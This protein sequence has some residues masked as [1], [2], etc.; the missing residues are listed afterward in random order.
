MHQARL[1]IGD[2]LP[3][4]RFFALANL[5]GSLRRVATRWVSGTHLSRFGVLCARDA[6]RVSGTKQTARLQLSRSTAWFVCTK[7]GLS[8]SCAWF[9]PT[10]SCLPRVHIISMVRVSYLPFFALSC[11]L[12]QVFFHS[13]SLSVPLIKLFARF[14]SLDTHPHSIYTYLHEYL[15]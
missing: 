13:F 1:P 4:A 10:M 14:F 6:D 9:S 11:L 7:V 5:S 15:P 8:S 12:D 3:W 2:V